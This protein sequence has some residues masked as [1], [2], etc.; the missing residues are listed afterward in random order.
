[1]MGKPVIIL[2][3][4]MMLGAC[5]TYQSMPLND[6]PATLDEIPHLTVDVKQ[7][8]LPELPAHPFAPSNRGLDITDVAILAVVN[9][10]DL[11][12]ARNDVA[13]AHAQAFSASLL[14]DPQ[15]AMSADFN[16]NPDST[17]TRGYS[18][19]PSYDFGSLL[20]HSTLR[21]A[22]DAESRKTD[23]TLLWQEWQVVAQARL[24]FIKLTQG[25]K[26]AQLLR[27]HR[28]FFAQRY[29]HHSEALARGL[30]TADTA[31]TAFASLQDIDKQ[32]ND[33]ER[34][35]N[36]SRHD[37]NA[38]LGLA[39]GVDVPLYGTAVLPPL[40]AG[41]IAE[42][43][44]HIAQRRPDL[45]ALQYGY[46]AQDERYRAAIIAQFPAMTI[47]LTRTRDTANLSSQGFNVSLSLPVF[48]R[49]RGNIAIEK[50]TR[51][52]L[53]D[54]YRQRI[55][56][57]RSD[58]DRILSTQSIDR[59]QMAEVDA[60]VRQLESQKQNLLSAFVARSVDE[61]MLSTIDTALLAKQTEQLALQQMA[62][63]QRV[64]L[65]SLLGGELPVQLQ[66]NQ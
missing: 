56:V 28:D 55:D 51:Q 12:A 64:A 62:L 13:I 19:G 16:R 11:K 34:Q 26:L 61:L 47:G 20:T 21:A 44:S 41:G 48:N 58:I 6:R 57:A 17:S 23:L 53:Y 15:L 66:G 22:A 9:N 54:D 40:D 59:R 18:I 8:P 46:A 60:S 32:I 4:V 35:N 39:P 33:L 7:L 38:L 37:L 10:P 43:L 27:Q 49:N 45:L 42:M 14:P 50:A 3:T 25:D 1:M 30:I 36:Q 31:T 52:K 2:L 65:Q 63:E 29:R 24:L 5:S